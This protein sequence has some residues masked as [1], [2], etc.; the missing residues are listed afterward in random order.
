MCASWHASMHDVSYLHSNRRQ[1]F[2][3]RHSEFW[4][5]IHNSEF[6][7]HSPTCI[8]ENTHICVYIHMCVNVCKC[9]GHLHTFTHLCMYTPRP[10]TTAG[11]NGN[12]FQ[13]SRTPYQRSTAFLHKRNIF[14]P[15]DVSLQ[16]LSIYFLATCCSVL[17]CVAVG[18]RTLRRGL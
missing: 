9:Q 12:P 6:V 1:P 11:Q 4:R 2:T 5:E 10:R 14:H 13:Q 16:F 18:C 15:K 3:P 8:N 17:Q 7:H